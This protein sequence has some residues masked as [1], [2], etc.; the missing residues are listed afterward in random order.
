MIVDLHDREA[1]MSTKTNQKKVYSSSLP[2]PPLLVV[3]SMVS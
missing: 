2:D 1:D 3:P